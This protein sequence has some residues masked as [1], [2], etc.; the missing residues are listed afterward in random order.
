MNYVFFEGDL[1]QKLCTECANTT[2]ELEGILIQH[3]E[4]K[5]NYKKMFGTTP[6]YLH[7]LCIF[8]EI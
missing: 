2:T 1:C 3:R 7:H 5:N 8:G 6:N 4:E